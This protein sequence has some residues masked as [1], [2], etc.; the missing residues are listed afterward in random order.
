[1]HTKLIDNHEKGEAVSAQYGEHNGEI[2]V[3]IEYLSGKEAA[4]VKVLVQDGALLVETLRYHD[5]LFNSYR[6]ATLY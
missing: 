4:Q 1:M 2:V 3:E 6:I 5:K